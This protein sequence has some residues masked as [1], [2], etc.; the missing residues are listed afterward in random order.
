MRDFGL[1]INCNLISKEEKKLIRIDIFNISQA[2]DFC[3]VKIKRSR[4]N[5]TNELKRDLQIADDAKQHQGTFFS[6][7][8][9]SIDLEF[10]Y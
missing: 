2:I 9:Y 10:N 4:H 5:I 1:S 6:F 3:L 7:K 8:I